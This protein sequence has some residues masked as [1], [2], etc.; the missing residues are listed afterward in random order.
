MTIRDIMLNDVDWLREEQSRAAS[1]KKIVKIDA[2][3]A[4]SSPPTARRALRPLLL[5]T[6]S[7]R[8]FC[9]CRQGLEGVITTATWRHERD[10]SGVEEVP[11]RVVIGGGCSDWRRQRLKLA[12]LNVT[13]RASDGM[14]DGAP[15]RLHRGQLLRQSLEAKGLQFLL[16]KQTAE[17]VATKMAVCGPF[18]SR[19]V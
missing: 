14:A 4:R 9:R 3:P 8:S 2:V 16:Q 5:A 12:A 13:V 18:A 17:I 19:T 11:A 15:A 1:R 7:N 6:G 10:D